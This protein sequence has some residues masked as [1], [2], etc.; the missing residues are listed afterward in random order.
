MWYTL[1]QIQKS[2]EDHIEKNHPKVA[3]K[4]GDTDGNIESKS[5]R[6]QLTTVQRP[7]K[8][9][10]VVMLDTDRDDDHPKYE[11][12]FGVAASLD[13]ATDLYLSTVKGS[14]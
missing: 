7:N 8:G 11:K 13:K 3:E 2:F 6:Y 9:L 14:E 4:W 10:E 12:S 5:G 1:Q